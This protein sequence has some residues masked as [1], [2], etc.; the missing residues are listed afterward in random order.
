MSPFT[1]S[2]MITLTHTFETTPQLDAQLDVLIIPGGMGCF[3]PD[4]T[5]ALS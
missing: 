4:P 3:D 2:Q 5:K 1:T